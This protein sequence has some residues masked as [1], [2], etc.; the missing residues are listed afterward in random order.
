MTNKVFHVVGARPNF[1]K[2]APLYKALQ[3]N[4]FSQKLIHTGQH[5]DAIMSDIF[6]QQ[7]QIPQPDF[8]LGIGSG[9]HT[10]QIAKTML[11]L[12]AILKE[13]KPV[14]MIVYGDVNAT[15]AAT[16]VAVKMGIR[17]AHVEAGLR[18]YDRTM[19]EEINRIITDSVADI[20]F[21]PSS[22]ANDNLL[23][24]GVSSDKIY[25]VGNIMIDSLCFALDLMQNEP[26]YVEKAMKII[27][28]L[29]TSSYILSTVHRPS[30]VD[31]PE[32]L[33][34]LFDFF[35]K[36]AANTHLILPL[37]PRTHKQL[38]KYNILQDL[39][40]KMLVIEPLS[41][42]DFIF[43][44]KNA[45]CVLTDSGGV[46]EESTFLS[47][48]CF[49]LRENTERPITITNGTNTLVGNDYAR[50]IELIENT[51]KQ[52]YQKPNPIELWDGKTSE[53][54]SQVLKNILEI[55]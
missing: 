30:N 26:K 9:S 20:L 3:K 29:N 52:K 42:F 7:L 13:E 41:Y 40:Q 36:I 32:E 17:I 51:K 49:T 34:K 47:I 10:E 37:H 19:P 11:A 54:I 6:F 24:E 21:T 39:P 55:A 50:L 5:Y 46:Q 31:K 48:P 4:K 14:L 2:L 44:Q 12:E 23:R 22:D 53:R 18:S 1:M 33:M 28:N 16:L 45:L 35:K 38:E 25:L 15:L 27:E 8:H 43:L